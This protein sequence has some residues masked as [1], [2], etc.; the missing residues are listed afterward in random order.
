MTPGITLGNLFWLFVAGFAIWYWWRSKAIKDG[1]VH[2][3]RNYCKS[4]DVMLLDD[5]VYL[6]GLW[7]KRDDNGSLR[8]WRRFMFDFTV[9]GESAIW[10]ASSCSV[11]VSFTVNWTPTGSGPST[12]LLSFTPPPTGQFFY[13]LNAWHG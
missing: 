7:F 5:A 4:M 13:Q 12:E 9:T 8:V 10:D 6:R 1:V 3:A 11:P 2:A